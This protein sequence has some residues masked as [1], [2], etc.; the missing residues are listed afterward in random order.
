MHQL[1][2]EVS[3]FFFR[4]TAAFFEASNVTG[5]SGT[6]IALLNQTAGRWNGEV[7]LASPSHII[8]LPYMKGDKNQVIEK[9]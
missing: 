5:L 1:F 4:F 2:P 3:I 6:I 7:F 9:K 8:E